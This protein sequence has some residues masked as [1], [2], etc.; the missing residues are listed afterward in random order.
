MKSIAGSII[1]IVL[2]FSLTACVGYRPQNLSD[3]PIVG[4]GWFDGGE[5]VP[6]PDPAEEIPEMPEEGEEIEEP[7]PGPTPWVYVPPKPPP[8]PPLSK[9][10]DQY[11]E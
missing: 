4:D 6:T 7:T 11:E 9:G 5:P 8:R 2:T 10:S 1:L 3:K